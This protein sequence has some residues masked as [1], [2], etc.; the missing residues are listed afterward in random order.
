MILQYNVPG[1]PDYLNRQLNDRLDDLANILPISLVRNPVIDLAYLK[2]PEPTGAA[3]DEILEHNR[4][5]DEFTEGFEDGEPDAI[6]GYFE[7]VLRC[8]I[9]PD[10]FHKNLRIAYARSR[11]S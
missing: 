9:Y 1:S 3:I 4:Q 6:S 7:L 10:G 2:K 5:I 8:S 11:S